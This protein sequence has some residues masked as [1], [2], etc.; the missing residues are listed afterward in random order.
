LLI[1]TYENSLPKKHPKFRPNKQVQPIMGGMCFAPEAFLK[2]QLNAAN[3]AKKKMPTLLLFTPDSRHLTLRKKSPRPRPRYLLGPLA[4]CQ[5]K[6]YMRPIPLR[7]TKSDRGRPLVKKRPSNLQRPLR[8]LLQNS[9]NPGPIRK[10]RPRRLH[11]ALTIPLVL[12][13]NTTRLLRRA[14]RPKKQQIQNTHNL[15]ASPPR[16]Y[17]PSSFL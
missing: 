3:A 4:H 17:S 1:A 10:N 12:P 2:R 8:R 6:R 13:E 5:A 16:K 9:S 14:K 7:R 15:Y 11:L